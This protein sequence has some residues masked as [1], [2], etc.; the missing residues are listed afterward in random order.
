METLLQE[1]RYGFRTLIKNPLFTGIAVLCLALAI[2]ANSA[3]FTVVNSVLLSPLPFED[4]ENLYRL[5]NVRA[6]DD[7][8]TDTYSLSPLSYV[9]VQ[10][11]SQSFAG[12][13][14]SRDRTFSLT[15]DGPPERVSGASATYNLFEVLG[16]EMLR[17]R[18]FNEEEDTPN[19][20]AVA[21]LS[22]SLWQRRFAG[23]ES[24]LGST[25]SFDDTAYTVV[26][27]LPPGAAFPAHAEAWV[28]LAL[29]PENPRNRTR[30]YLSAITRL[31]PGTDVASAQSEMDIIAQRMAET[32]PDSN[33]KLTLWLRPLRDRLIGDGDRAL[34]ILLVAVGFVLLIACTAVAS[35]LLAR[36]ATLAMGVA[37]RVSLGASRWRLIRQFLIEGFLLALI[38]GA[39]GLLLAVLVLPL[40]NTLV[41][42]DFRPYQDSTIDLRVL[43]FTAS[44][45]F[46]TSI[47]FGLLPAIRF[48]RVPP[49]G[50]LYGGRSAAGRGVGGQRLQ[51]ALVVLQ[52]AVAVVL[53]IATG[54][55]IRSFS[56][57]V[58]IDPG[59]NSDNG[60][61]MR[62]TPPTSRYPESAQQA[63]FLDEVLER[64][65][66]LP[67]VT[68]V[69]STTTL[70][71]TDRDRNRAARFSVEGQLPEDPSDVNVEHY[72]M[73]NPEFFQTMGIPLLRGRNFT[74]Q[75]RADSQGVVIVSQSMAERYWPGEDPIGKRLK[76]GTYDSDY[77][78]LSIVGVVADV[79]DAGIHA[80]N[81]RDWYLPFA[82][83]PR[84]TISLVVKVASGD[85]LALSEAASEAI[86]EVDPNLP[87][88]GVTTLEE[89]VYGPLDQNRFNASV[90]GGFSLFGLLLAAVGLYGLMSIQVS[91]RTPEISM[92][93]A[94]G[95][96]RR[97]I[98]GMMLRRA[99]LLTAIGLA[100][101][102]VVALAA[103]SWIK[104][105][106]FGV[107]PT[108]P[109]TVVIIVAV[110]GICALTASFVPAYRATRIQPVEG[111]RYE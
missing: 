27:I 40:L 61:V 97:D 84:P 33:K 57:L 37:V 21:I 83:N 72:R 76:R 65:A 105:L 85:P 32:Y 75:D 89:V 74:H 107:E 64:L 77:S 31:A 62:L 24:T 46:L 42:P 22:Y 39:L 71:I 44:V 5:Y 47:F 53:L 36:G 68:A 81:K 78:W 51:S 30:H 55:L 100:A 95:A 102:I 43:G 73:I 88:H 58:Q 15:G 111:L 104:D 110:L 2:G 20:P 1:F 109:A 17:G 26:G 108:D 25:V 56:N 35:L 12:M 18:A 91:Q 11:Q 66:A 10:A 69:G 92:R 34:V 93:M 82:Q 7:G 41:P 90:V 98:L 50:L 106:L 70:P 60:L 3:I 45:A 48:S 54:L 87:V 23:E 28:P 13:A 79:K 101:G 59:F 86:W 80:D 96:Q 52:L 9:E 63:D 67:G 94:L 8:S 14:I 29:D 103:G 19:G 99:A 6:R 38:S 49:Q 4:A 16:T